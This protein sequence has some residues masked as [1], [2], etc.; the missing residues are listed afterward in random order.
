MQFDRKQ[1]R[2]SPEACKVG[3]EQY[4]QM[5]DD[6]A[7]HLRSYIRRLGDVD[8]TQPLF[9]FVKMMKKQGAPRA[10]PVWFSWVPSMDTF[11]RDLAHA[12]IEKKDKS[13]RVVVFHSLRKSRSLLSGLCA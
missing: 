7:R 10:E 6:L 4:V 12:G 2:V 3:E 11:D 5:D 8:D 9:G 1:I 13:D